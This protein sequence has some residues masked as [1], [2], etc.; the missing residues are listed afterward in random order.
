MKTLAFV[1]ALLIAFSADVWGQISDEQILN[2][3][4][5]A[6]G[7]VLMSRPF[8]ITDNV[9]QEVIG[10]ELK[11]TFNPNVF[12]S[13]EDKQYIVRIERSIILRAKDSNDYN[14]KEVW[15]AILNAT[16]GFYIPWIDGSKENIKQNHAYYALIAP[17]KYLMTE[18]FFA[19][20]PNL[21]WF[22]K[23]RH[24][25]KIRYIE[26]WYGVM[27][28]DTS[29]AQ[30][31]TNIGKTFYIADSIPSSM[32]GVDVELTSNPNVFLYKKSKEYIICMATKTIIDFKN[33][34]RFYHGTELFTR[35]AYQRDFNDSVIKAASGFYIPS[36]DRISKK[37]PKEEKTAQFSL[38]MP[39]FKT[40]PSDSLIRLLYTFKNPPINMSKGI[41]P[42]RPWSVSV[43][44]QSTQK[45]L[46]GIMLIKVQAG[47]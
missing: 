33:S 30:G 9:P 37:L 39:S 25:F 19:I 36:P 6:N 40:K 26:K 5:G 11:S 20:R 24:E 28:G 35:Y 7:R 16:K 44:N 42:N 32:I 15:G 3:T 41:A 14:F 18:E 38:L 23:K 31:R 17:P 29:A 13:G 34:Y 12:I 27:L 47:F 8:F 21:G 43:E 46:P 22:S 10:N 1:V 45:I 4:T 2:D